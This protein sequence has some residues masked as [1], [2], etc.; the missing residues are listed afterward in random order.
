MPAWLFHPSFWV[1]VLLL[2]G[3][4]VRVASAN[5]YWKWFDS[6]FPQTWQVSKLDLSQN[7]MQYA[8]QADPGTW[9]SPHFQG[10]D[11]RPY[12]RP[13]LAS[14]YFVGLFR[15]FHFNRLAVSATQ[16]LLATVA[17]LF[18]YLLVAQILGRRIGLLALVLLVLHPVLMFEDT[19]FED[20]VLG[21]LFVSAALLAAFWASRG[22]AARW[23]LPGLAVG[24]AMLARP[25]L[26]VVAAG[27]AAL[28][29]WQ[30]RKQRGKRV[31]ALVAPI[32]FLIMPAAWHNHETSGRWILICDI[33]GQNLY[34]GNGLFDDHRQSV[35]GYWDIREVDFGSPGML[36]VNGLKARSGKS[37]TDDAFLAGAIDFVRAH[38]GKAALGLLRKAWRHVSNYEIPRDRDFNWLRGHN[39]WWQL[40]LLPF[41]LVLGFA[42]LGIAG[43]ER[44]QVFL[45]GLP[46]LA[47]FVSEVLFF[48]TSRY[49]A[50]A[51][52]FVIPL[53]LRGG[54]LFF[55]QVRDWRRYRAVSMSAALLIALFLLG[56]YAVGE[57]EHVGEASVDAFKAAM[58]ESYADEAGNWRWISEERFR[59]R[60]AE[61]R[62][63]D[64][65]N[66]D[67]FS[68]EQ[69]VLIS[70]G[71]SD[72]A[73]QNI[74]ER[75][76]RCRPGEWLCED[77]CNYVE[78][79]AGATH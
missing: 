40:P 39:R 17:Y 62:R 32:L 14:Y 1:G 74:R 76:A 31:A 71:N 60:L 51:L 19:S 4:L 27:L 20:S 44:R 69:K 33:T 23:L 73:M 49:R 29:Y 8:L 21:M 9:N 75:R 70:G 25:N 36:L 59:R 48:N 56:Q 58:L 38:P 79:D 46:W 41:S 18:A 55:S 54:A 78:M 68:V 28:A 47:I 12:F 13:P 24:L 66:L 15:L 37:A 34:W 43:L 67:A 30:A 5:A 7:G 65:D 26:G 11:D 16:A 53:A 63:L 57:K 35:Q 22:R 6:E 52:P 77:V 61:A 42:L 45:L 2:V 64:P 3:F 50:M 72:R 10:W